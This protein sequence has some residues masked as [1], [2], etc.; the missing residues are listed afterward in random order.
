MAYR[1]VLKIKIEIN[2]FVLKPYRAKRPQ[3][4]RFPGLI[5][6]SKDYLYK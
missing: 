5:L 4:E 2:F 1:I 6:E 3:S